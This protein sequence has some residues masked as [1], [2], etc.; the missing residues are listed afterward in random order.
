MPLR[1][2]RRFLSFALRASAVLVLVLIV[3]A[4]AVWLTLPEVSGLADRKQ[5][6]TFEVRDWKGR[7]HPFLLGPKN[8]R[9]TPLQRIPKAMKWAVIVAEDAN[10][11]EHQGIDVPALKEAMEYNLEQKRMARGASTITQQLAKN[12]FLSREKSLLR[13]GREVLIARRLEGA[14]TKERILELYL[15]VV[16]LGPLVHGVG[17]GA[18]FHFGKSV[19]ELT[20]ADCAVLAAIL[21]GPRVAYNPALR[22][23]RVKNRAVRILRLLKGR[24]V[25]SSDQYAAALTQLTGRP[26]EPAAETLDPAEDEL[27]PVV[28]EE[29]PEEGAPPE[30]ISTVPFAPVQEIPPAV[31]PEPEGSP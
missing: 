14:L 31:V 19:G 16:E 29:L 1:P 21:P 23:E 13:K 25:L 30:E 27:E 28:E 4:V 8:P 22:P 18:R 10:F 3:A 9:W 2:L 20:P 7:E 6:L 17:A 12:V 24:G 15:N 26:P 11:Y 5:T